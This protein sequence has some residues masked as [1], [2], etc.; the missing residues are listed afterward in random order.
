MYL[1]RLIAWASCF[2]ANGLGDYHQKGV[3][4]DVI[5]NKSLVA[6]VFWIDFIY[7]ASSLEALII[8]ACEIGFRFLQLRKSRH[9]RSTCCSWHRFYLAHLSGLQANLNPIEEF[10]AELKA[11]IKK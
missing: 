7:I 1:P 5:L 8:V 4:G 6:S 3:E 9:K 11:F 2:F 10:F